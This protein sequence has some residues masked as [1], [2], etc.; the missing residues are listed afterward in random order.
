LSPVKK[1]FNMIDQF[2]DILA[3][4]ADL[5]PLSHQLHAPGV[6]FIKPFTALSYDFSI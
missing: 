1:I 6:N 3:S 5:L 2:Q 4:P